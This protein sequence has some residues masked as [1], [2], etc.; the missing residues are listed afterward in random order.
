[1]DSSFD[2]SIDQILIV[3]YFIRQPVSLLMFHVLYYIVLNKFS[4]TLLVLEAA[5]NPCVN[6][7][8]L[9]IQTDFNLNFNHWKY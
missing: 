4:S 2:Q 1:M 9:E 8:C 6:H 7:R 5:L 3:Y